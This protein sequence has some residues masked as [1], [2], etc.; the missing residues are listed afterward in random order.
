MTQENQELT[1]KLLAEQFIQVASM[2]KKPTTSE[3]ETLSSDALTVRVFTPETSKPVPTDFGLRVMEKITDILSGAPVTNAYKAYIIDEM[4]KYTES[5]MLRVMMDL[6][7]F[8]ILTSIDL[9]KENYGVFDPKTAKDAERT[10]LRV[11]C[12]VTTS[13]IFGR[14]AEDM[15]AIENWGHEYI[16]R[17]K[18]DPLS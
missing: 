8:S 16:D 12:Q 3:E 18:E 4:R 7:D 17:Y 11:H 14:R 10:A 9:Q 6:D 13:R 1:P 5:P 2:L 15:I